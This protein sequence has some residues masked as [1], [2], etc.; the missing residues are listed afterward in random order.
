MVGR[1]REITGPFADM[2]GRAML[3][4]GGSL[5]LANHDNVIGPGHASVLHADGQDWLVHHFYD[6]NHFA[7]A[8][9]QINPISWKD[10]GWPAVGAAI[11]TPTTRP[12]TRSS[13]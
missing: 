9:L 7:R 10:D 3:D 13:N 2:S 12:T 1:S 6:A 11:A 5:V 4:G 8:T